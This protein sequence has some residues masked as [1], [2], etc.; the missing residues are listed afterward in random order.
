MSKTQLMDIS[1]KEYDKIIQNGK[2]LKPATVAKY[3][4]M[5]NGLSKKLLVED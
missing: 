2:S 1:P 4:N 3:V 5:E